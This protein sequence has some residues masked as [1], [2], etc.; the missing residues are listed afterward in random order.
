MYCVYDPTLRE[1]NEEKNFIAKDFNEI[2]VTMSSTPAHIIRTKAS[3]KVKIHYYGKSMQELK[4]SADIKD[5]TL[6][7]AANR[8][9]DGPIPEI[10]IWI[11]IS[12]KTMRKIFPLKFHQVL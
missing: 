4:L 10:C 1:I 7:V 8:E 2:Q 11:Y 6:I 5:S 3:D 9:I 12:Q